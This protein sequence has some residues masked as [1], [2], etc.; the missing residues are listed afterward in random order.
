MQ[1]RVMAEPLLANTELFET[2]TKQTVHGKETPKKKV[3]RR[4]KKDS[5]EKV[6]YFI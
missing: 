6:C 2:I 1:Q 3:H 4:S 5:Q